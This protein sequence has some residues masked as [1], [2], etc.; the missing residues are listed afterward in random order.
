MLSVSRSAPLSGPFDGNRAD[1]S[2]EILQL[3]ISAHP[4]SDYTDT[5]SVTFVSETKITGRH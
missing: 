4:L 2:G 3:T 1:A 5:S